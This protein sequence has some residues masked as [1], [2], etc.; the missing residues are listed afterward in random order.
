[1]LEMAMLLSG[2]T[3]L[4]VTVARTGIS[5]FSKEEIK[6]YTKEEI[7]FFI[8]NSNLYRKTEEEKEKIIYPKVVDIRETERVMEIEFKDEFFTLKNFEDRKEL[9]QNYFKEAQLIEFKYNKDRNIVVKLYKEIMKPRYNFEYTLCEAHEF[10]GG[11]DLYENKHI[12]SLR[13]NMLLAGSVG[14]GKTSTVQGIL[15]NRLWNNINN[16]NAIFTSLWIVDLK[17]VDLTLFEG[18]KGVENIATTSQEAKEVLIKAKEEMTR[19]NNIFKAQKVSSIEDYNEKNNEKM[20]FIY[21]VLDEIATFQELPKAEK[22]ELEKLLVVLASKS[23][24]CGI[25]IIGAT[26]RPDSKTLDSFVKAQLSGTIVGH[27]VNN[28]HT[29]S[30]VINKPGLEL[31]QRPGQALVISD[32]ETMTQMPYVSTKELKARL[33]KDIKKR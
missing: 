23:R 29:S 10:F 18:Y 33:Q 8:K 6:S 13:R 4:G 19:R 30:T 16:P 7:E 24:S 1:M 12:V 14:Q 2:M 27:R 20:N 21:L 25:I 3:M 26:Q 5:Y 31:L 17:G 28:E 15:L 11:Y 9:F 32:Q 22:E